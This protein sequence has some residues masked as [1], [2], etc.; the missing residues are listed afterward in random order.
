MA[1]LDEKQPIS[2][3]LKRL[4]FLR[5]KDQTGQKGN[6]ELLKEM[7]ESDLKKKN[8]GTQQRIHFSISSQDTLLRAEGISH[9]PELFISLE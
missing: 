2:R 9:S 5:S 1:R 7:G 8:K 4:G 3:S 6:R